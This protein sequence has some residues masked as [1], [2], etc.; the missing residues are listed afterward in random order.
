MEIE[1]NTASFKD[2]E[3][4][5]GLDAWKRAGLFQNYLNYLDNNGRLNYRLISSSGCGPEMNILT[6]DHP[7]ARKMVSFVS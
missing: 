2:F 5:D 7:K 6:K 4:V 3:N 1:F